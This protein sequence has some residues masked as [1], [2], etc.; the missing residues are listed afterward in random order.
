MKVSLAVSYALSCADIMKVLFCEGDH[1]ENFGEH[2][3]TTTIAELRAT[4]CALPGDSGTPT[5][6][7]RQ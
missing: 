7:R 6:E 4:T 3:L 2:S 1:R 5:F